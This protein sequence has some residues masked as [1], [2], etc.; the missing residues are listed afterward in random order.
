MNKL[1]ILI[2]QEVVFEYD[3]DNILDEQKRAFLN[4][5]DADM[6]RGI[7]I[8]GEMIAGA[9]AQQRAKFVGMNLI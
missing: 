1:S 7:K 8:Q 5:M 4:K 2:N 6:D 9:D 3:R